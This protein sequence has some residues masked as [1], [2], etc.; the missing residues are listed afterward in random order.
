MVLGEF[1]PLEKFMDEEVEVD[2]K[3]PRIADIPESHFGSD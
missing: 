3:I 1:V 2:R